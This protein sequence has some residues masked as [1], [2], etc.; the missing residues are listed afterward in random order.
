MLADINTWK[1]KGANQ[2]L[3]ATSHVAPKKLVFW[4]EDLCFRDLLVS[5]LL[6]TLLESLQC[7]QIPARI[8]STTSRASL[9]LCE[10]RNFTLQFVED[11]CNELVM[12]QKRLHVNT[13]CWAMQQWLGAIEQ[14]E[15][16]KPGCWFATKVPVQFQRIVV[17]FKWGQT[18]S[19]KKQFLLKKK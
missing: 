10:V 12:L 4:T 15:R 14:K 3:A 6:M 11:L 16:S 1:A 8:R 7:L 17:K 13:D 9:L 19:T 18:M 2:C 5:F